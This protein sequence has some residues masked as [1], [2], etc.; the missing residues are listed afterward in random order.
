MTFLP[1]LL[2]TRVTRKKEIQECSCVLNHLENLYMVKFSE[3]V[4]IGGLDNYDL[5]GTGQSVGCC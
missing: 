1:R 4:T 3:L 5:I 2:I